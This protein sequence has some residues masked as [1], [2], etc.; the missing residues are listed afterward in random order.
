MND[1]R[2]II[3]FLPNLRDFPMTRY[4]GLGVGW[5][6]TPK[7]GTF[8]YVSKVSLGREPPVQLARFI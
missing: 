4:V 2:R 5:T 8:Y 7:R 3:E 1:Y 6:R